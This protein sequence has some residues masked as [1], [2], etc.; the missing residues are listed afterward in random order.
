MRENANAGRSNLILAE[1]IR[2]VYKAGYSI[3]GVHV[4]AATLLLVGL[5]DKLS[6]LRI[7]IWF[8]AVCAIQA[9]CAWWTYSFNRAAPEAEQMALWARRRVALGLALGALWGYAALGLFP[10]E[11]IAG[12]ALLT[13]IIVGLA[14][15]SL[16]SSAQYLPAN[17]GLVIPM[18]LALIGRTAVEG[19]A[20]YLITAALLVIYMGFV[21]YSARNLNHV[22]IDSLRMRFE[23]M[24]LIEALKAQTNAAEAA[25][26][27]AE[28]ANQSKS[29]FLAAASHD[30][31]Q[32]LHALGLFAAALDARIRYPEV[33][34]IVSNIN[35]SI[36]ALEAL[37]NELLDVSKLDAGVILP[38]RTSFPVQRLFE[39]IATDYATQAVQRGLEFT[40][41]PS[42]LVLYSDPMLLERIVR[43]L[44]SNSIRYT[45]KGKVLVGVR[46][47][48]DEARI[49]VWDTGTGIPEDQR[50][51]I[52]EEFYQLTNPER[53][54]TK[55]LGL[56][57]AIVKRLTRLLGHALTMNS[58]VGKGSVFRVSVPI[59][60][61][62]QLS[63]PSFHGAEASPAG[64]GGKHIVFI[65]DEAA[66]REGMDAL[67]KQWGYIVTTAGSL[68][69]ALRRL[70]HT[71]SA[72]DLIIADYRLRAGASGADA[73]RSVQ[74]QYG[75]H[76]PGILITGDT[77]PD[78]ILEARASGYELLHKP[79][80]PARLRSLIGAMTERG[81]TVPH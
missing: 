21:L 40:I 22:L 62:T 67:L 35:S 75:K 7:G 39:R 5:W 59:G 28:A 56:G 42:R 72:P 60:R 81:Q 9:V 54:R 46:R 17:Y 32:P 66:V 13:M 51:K 74:A 63:Q 36:A 80:A 4:I 30:L 50:E 68:E 70:E 53:D 69:E 48:G 6:P 45:P 58:Q 43:N 25:R 26:Q 8:V 79:V 14:A 33:R 15:G 24:D 3:A 49:E 44:V 16:T 65:D 77:A 37:F 71:V 19:G 27:A 73:I 78:R 57:L 11:H 41:V 61:L 29:Q 52:F 23:N 18:L 12:Q 2:A 1:Q 47:Q 20:Q 55:G 34:S 31:R 76:T 10:S 38:S 64:G